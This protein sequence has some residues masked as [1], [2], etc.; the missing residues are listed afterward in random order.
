[1]GLFRKHSRKRRIFDLCLLATL[2][3][4]FYSCADKM[5]FFPPKSSY[6]D[7]PEVIKI[8]VEGS[9]TISAFYLPVFD[10]EYTLLF[11]HGNAEDIGQNVN[12][13]RECQQKG[14]GVFAYDYRGYGTSDGKPSEQNTYKD[15]EAAYA[16]LT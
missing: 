4:F 3:I 14:Y 5:M 6:S 8:P 10:G 12:F 13:F 11:S 16:Y 2:P 9:E 1:M 15:I 7:V